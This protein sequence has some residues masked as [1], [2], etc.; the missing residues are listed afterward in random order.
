M[1]VSNSSLRRRQSSTVPSA[2]NRPLRRV[3]S[4]KRTRSSIGDLSASSSTGGNDEGATS[5]PSGKRSNATTKRGG[6]VA[7]NNNNARQQQH[8]HKSPKNNKP[9]SGVVACLSGQSEEIKDRSH[10]IIT[11]LGGTTMGRFDPRYVTHLILDA[12]TGSKY[13][14]WKYN[15]AN[16]I[17][18]ERP[19][20]ESA[21]AKELKVVTTEWVEACEGE[22]RRVDEEEYKLQEEDGQHLDARKRS[23][24][25]GGPRQQKM[26][27]QQQVERTS[28]PKEIQ[29]AS[30]SEKCDWM[31]RHKPVDEYCNLFSRQSFILVGFDDENDHDNTDAAAISPKDNGD[32]KA[33][34]SRLP[35]SSGKKQQKESGSS[36]NDNDL[37]PFAIRKDEYGTVKG[38][39][40][41][42][43]RR[44][45]GPYTGNRTSR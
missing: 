1:N 8:H 18:S 11:R 34:G 16:A 9:L 32:G 7:A 17:S 37:G 2:F 29:H 3:P 31:I 25:A 36:K 40:S 6:A 45:G 15:H 41:K 35:P 27:H 26:A 5:F 42:L 21:W 44:A 12:P 38:K 20:S 22:G 23:S 43:I 39:I 14:S 28:L 19:S 24:A 10:T 33:D 13:E 30:L 4:K